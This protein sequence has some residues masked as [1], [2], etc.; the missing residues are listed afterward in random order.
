MP[1]LWRGEVEISINNQPC[2]L[3]PTFSALSNIEQTLSAGLPSLA[4]R[5]SDGMLTLEELVTIIACCSC[6]DLTKERIRDTLIED[7]IGGAME[8]IAIMFSY[9]F[10]NKH[11]A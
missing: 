2:I 1:N 7:G 9:I 4:M 6:S 5:L 10:K 3:R 11:E 8:Q